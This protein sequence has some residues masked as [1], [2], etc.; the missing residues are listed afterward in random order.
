[1]QDGAVVN[2][3]G[4]ILV[5]LLILWMALHSSKIIFAVFVNLFIG[6]SIT[7][8]AGPDDGG[9]VQPALDRVRRSVRRIGRRLR[10][11]VQRPLPLRA[12]QEQRSAQALEKAADAV[13]VPLSLAAMATAAGFLSFLPT[14]YKGISELGKIAGVGMLVAFLSSITVLPA[15]LRLLNPPGEKE[16]VGYAFLA[17]VDHFLEK[18]R[19]VII[20]G[21]LLVAIAG[22]P[23]LYFLSSTSTRSICEIPRPNSI[24]TF[25]DLRKDP[26]TGANAI[27]VMTNSEADAKKIEARLEKVPEVLE[28]R[29]LD[30]FVPEDQPAKLKLIAQGAKVL[31]PALNPDS[32]DAAP[33][34]QENVEALKETAESLRK[35]AGDAKGPGRWL[36]GGLPMR[37]RNLPSPTGHARQDPGD[38]RDAPEDRARPAQ[39]PAAGRS[40][41][42]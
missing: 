14:D 1:M 41:S 26:N 39:E 31:D 34:D 12:L 42:A 10:H 40:R 19:I 29:S 11:P 3:I 18:H 28:V 17:P 16:P 24:S 22:L 30:S 35:T 36:R 20:V 6:L 27:D 23:L 7:T 13:A 33:S 8:A 25:L 21:T 5:V 38:L 2:G 9:F 32:I 37:C 4:T 15:L